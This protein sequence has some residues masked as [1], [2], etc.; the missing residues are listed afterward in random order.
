MSEKS[1]RRKKKFLFFAFFTLN[2]LEFEQLMCY[3]IQIIYKF[4][5]NLK[6]N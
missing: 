1:S 6:N 3:I 4:L 5:S 2:F